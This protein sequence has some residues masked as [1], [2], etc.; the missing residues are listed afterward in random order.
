MGLGSFCNLALRHLLTG[1]GSFCNSPVRRLAAGLGS[2]C[3]LALRRLPAHL[4]NTMRQRVRSPHDGV[5]VG[6]VTLH[7]V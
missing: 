6:F 3:N 2:F 5:G 1:L 4:F 7:P